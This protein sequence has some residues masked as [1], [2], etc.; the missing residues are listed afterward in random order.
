M[1]LPP[2]LVRLA[3]PV[4]Q[5]PQL[6]TV[7]GRSLPRELASSTRAQIARRRGCGQVLTES[8]REGTEEASYAANGKGYV[9]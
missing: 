3:S 6:T 5:I 7:S 2:P 4:V 1:W 9:Q 8:D